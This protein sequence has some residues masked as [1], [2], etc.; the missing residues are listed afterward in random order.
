MTIYG[1]ISGS[2]DC[3]IGK[4]ISLY[5][6]IAVKMD[7]SGGIVYIPFNNINWC[8]RK[9]V[10]LFGVGNLPFRCGI[11]FFSLLSNHKALTL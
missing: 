1:N 10:I 3:S 11:I 7:I 8:D 9:L 6:H 2:A 4:H 5:Q